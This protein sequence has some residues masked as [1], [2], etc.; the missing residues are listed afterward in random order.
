MADSAL[1]RAEHR[2]PRADTG[3]TWITRVPATLTA[4]QTT[5][6]QA[7]PEA[8]LPLRDGYRDHAHTGTYGR[9]PQRWVLID[10][11]PRRPQAQR[12]VDTHGL[13]PSEAE[14]Q[15]FQQLCHTTFACEAEAQHALATFTPGLSTTA[16]HAYHLR[17]TP[18]DRRRGRPGPG[19]PPDHVVYQSDGG[20][21]S[22]IAAQQSLV[23]QHR[24]FILATNALDA[25][26]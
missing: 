15:T 8:M 16:L 20:L 1:Y 21:A 18:R 26:L 14:G 24:G 2:Q 7:I 10:S 9:V 25:R 3:T 4:A 12:T 22:A 6:A 23:A 5:W 13:K 19:T 11:E 17:P